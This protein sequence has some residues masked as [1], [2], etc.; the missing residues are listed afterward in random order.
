MA[1]IASLHIYPV[2][3][4]RGIDVE[5]TLMTPTGPEW[6]RRWMIIQPPDQFITQRS[7]PRLATITVAIGDGKLCLS[8]AGHAPLA[9]DV[10][11]PG[12]SR[13][14]RI[15]DDA[16]LGIDAGDEAAAWLSRVLDDT[17]RLVRVDPA[18][19]R[20]ANPKYAG[21]Q[22]QPVTFADG[23]PILMISNE[24]LAELNRRLPEP[25]PMARFRPNLVIEGVPAHAEDAMTLYRSGPVVLR[26]VRLCTR[27][28][29]TTTDQLSGERDPHQQPLRALG[30]YRHDYTLKGVTFGQNCTLVAGVGERLRVGAELSIDPHQL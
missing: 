6:D 27:C 11:H 29:V 25:I 7:H 2:K 18:A 8:A 9:L 26:G 16:C 28:A 10:N 1:R 21:S 15:W 20:L 4:C 3:S 30:K 14:V 17:V 12:E 19:P 5:S 13:R 22:P 23:Y 24:S